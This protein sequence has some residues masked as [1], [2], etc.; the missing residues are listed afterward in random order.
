MLLCIK[1]QPEINRPKNKQLSK[2]RR[3]KLHVIQEQKE[4]T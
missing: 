2:E 4:K 3:R 1:E